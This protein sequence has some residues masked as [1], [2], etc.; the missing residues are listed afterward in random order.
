MTNQ[1]TESAEL[2][3]ISP[4][5][6]EIRLNARQLAMQALER[7]DQDQDLVALIQAVR[8]AY[9]MQTKHKDVVQRINRIIEER[10]GAIL[11]E[12]RV[13]VDHSRLT[14]DSLLKLSS[15]LLR[16]RFA[17]RSKMK[18][19]AELVLEIEPNNYTAMFHL[20]IAIV[21][22]DP[23]RAEHLF[24]KAFILAS[25]LGIIDKDLLFEYG[26]FLFQN[27]RGDHG[28]KHFEA[29][30]RNTPSNFKFRKLLYKSLKA[31]GE[32][33]KAKDFKKET[34]AYINSLPQ[35][36]QARAKALLSQ[37]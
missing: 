33:Q 17:H 16:D 11:R 4:E 28:R 6:S 20:A 1:P 2:Q 32:W 3:A 25:G 15:S 12:L 27:K 10:Y 13:K 29:L 22:D 36:E 31:N 8:N 21:Q 24:E 23:D 19:I 34:K 37:F 30:H 35:S 9:N 14:V 26:I 5:A 7:F 18:S